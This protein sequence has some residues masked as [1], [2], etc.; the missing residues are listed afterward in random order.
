M[1]GKVVVITG[2][3]GG[4]GKEA[5][6]GL[7]SRGATVVIVGRDAQKIAA[8][9]KELGVEFIAGD[10]G[11]IHDAK[12]IAR[13]VRERFQRIDVLVHNA[14]AIPQTRRETV[15]GN[16]EALAVNVLAPYVLT[17][18]LADL[19]KQSAPSRVVFLIGA[20][21]AVAFDDLQ[22]AK[23]EYNGWVAYQRSKTASLMVLTELAKRFA[24]TG[25]VVNGAFPGIV[26]TPGMGNAIASQPSV[27]SRI[28][29]TLMRPFMRTPA[30]G[31]ESTVWVASAPELERETGKLW[32]IQK[33]LATNMEPKGWNDANDV[34]RLVAELDKLVERTSAAQQAA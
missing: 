9:A 19:L 17:T 28:V 6:R 26:A 7:A 11:S 12:R 21:G 27:G 32:S 23:G 25:V 22:F 14:A 16:E 2:A 29:L 24:G 5:A 8:T 4:V 15:D 18:E 31:A 30:K 33:P 20:S 34:A 13:E 10:I 3:S 1:R